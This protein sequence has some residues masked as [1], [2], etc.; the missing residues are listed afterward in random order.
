MHAHGDDDVPEG[1][2]A[3]TSSTKTKTHNGE[4][5]TT[6]ETKYIMADGSTSTK[7][8]TN[9]EQLALKNH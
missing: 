7:A 2:I 4:K 9:T 6:K 1:C 3:V 8:I 5:V